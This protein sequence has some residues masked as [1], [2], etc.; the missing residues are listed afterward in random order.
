[1]R[2]LT[3]TNVDDSTIDSTSGGSKHFLSFIENEL[4]PYIGKKYPSKNYRTIVDHSLG[5]LSAKI[6]L[7]NLQSGN[8]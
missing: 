8:M 2:D 7:K 3:P 1:M 5:S 4:I 6:K